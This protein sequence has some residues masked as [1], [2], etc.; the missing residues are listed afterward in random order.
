MDLTIALAGNPNAGK[1][2]I[3]NHLTGARQKVGNWPGVTVEKK[4]G[5]V[6]HREHRVRVVDLPG[7]YSLTAYSVEEMVAR[8]YILNERPDVVVDILDASN[9][10][11]NLYLAVQLI[12]LNVRLVFAMNMVDVARARGIRVDYAHLGRLLGVPVVETVGTRGEGIDAL[13]DKAVEVAEGRDPVARHVH[14]NYGPEVEEEIALVR[15][16]VQKDPELAASCYP[17]WLAVK[18]IEGD[19]A[20]RRRVEESPAAAAVLAQVDRSRAHLQR[21]FSDDPETLIAEARY[22]FIAGALKECVRLSPAAKKTVSDRIDQVVTNRVLGFPVFLLIMYLLFQ[23]TFT[24]GEYPVSWIEAAVAWLGR[25]AGA[26]LPAGLLRDLVVDGVIGGVGGVIVFLPNIVLLFLGISLLEDTGYLARAAFIMDRVMHTLG[27]HGK[28]FIPLLMGFG[29][30]VP[31]IMA[32]RTLETRRDR[33]LTILIN[34]LMSCSARLP[35]YVL[36]AG[37]FFPGREGN[38]LFAMYLLGVT[39]AILVGQV[40]KRTLFRGE[41]SPFV[42]ELPPYRMP[43]G[44]SLVIH[45]WDRARV[46]LQKM[47]G[48][49]LAFSV[50]IWFLGA[51]PRDVPLERDYGAERARA[52]A[53]IQAAEAAAATPEAAAA[54]RAAAAERLAAIDRA[55][56]RD[57][58]A[59]SYIGRLGRWIEPVLRPLGFDWRLGVSL[60]TGF[61]AK[62]VVVSTL[63]VLFQAEGTGEEAHGL[64]AAL[65]RSGLTP[66]TAFGFMAFVLIYVPCVVTVVTIWR[67]TGSVGWTAF[68][69]S[70]LMVLAWIVAFLIR[71]GGTLARLAA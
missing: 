59:H 61:V 27:L 51:F 22:G 56:A 7:I 17:R 34:P 57:R 41:S 32:T 60:V 21:I 63:G 12:E 35:V 69:V 46:Y 33:I 10:E 44:R 66:V 18:L 68:A 11:R 65:R 39:L 42:M 58:V 45:M 26:A 19:P 54:L 4:E 43:T 23:G 9:L 28:S 67:E 14:V 3:F 71:W 24:L 70:Y 5:T 50:V 1:T 36:L 48:V 49:V 55:E 38:V 53:E 64:K 31:A 8:D 13:L 25:A 15:R 16:A 2:T 29:C 6:V 40:F 62:E 37:A 20:V 30:N 47:G 52:A